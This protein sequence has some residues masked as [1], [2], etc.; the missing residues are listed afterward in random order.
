MAMYALQVFYAGQRLPAEIQFIER[1]TE[2]LEQI[3][4]LLA[5]HGNCE[6]VLVLN[7]LLRLFAVD[8]AGNLTES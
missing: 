7:G 2:V 1:A 6:R 4:A 5:K 3:P 8:C